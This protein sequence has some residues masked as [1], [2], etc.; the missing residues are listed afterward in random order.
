[1]TN[2]LSEAQTDMIECLKF[3]KLDQEAIVAIMLLI[4]KDE[5][6]AEMAEFLLENPNSTQSD[7]LKKAVNISED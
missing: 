5:Q 1:M 7:I 2:K 4:P 6:I 3:L